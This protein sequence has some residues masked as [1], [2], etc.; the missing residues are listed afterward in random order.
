MFAKNSSSCGHQSGKS[1]VPAK[2][3]THDSRFRGNDG[4]AVQNIPFR[5][6][7]PL[8]RAL[9]AVLLPFLGARIASQEPALSK[10]RAKFGIENDQRPGDA[11]FGC[12]RLAVHAAAPGIDEDVELPRQLRAHQ[13]LLDLRAQRLG[14]KVAV[15]AAPVDGQFPVAG[16][17]NHSGYRRFA[18]PRRHVLSKLCHKDSCSL[19]DSTETLSF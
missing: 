14:G 12:T 16:P 7:E 2:A 18:T 13:R 6:L 10:T 9:L 15:E 5:E 3:G 4:P 8:A 19:F 17:E 11:Q 1:V